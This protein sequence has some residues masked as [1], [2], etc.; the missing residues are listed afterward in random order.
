[1]L[2]GGNE[3]LR[4]EHRHMFNRAFA[5]IG[6]TVLV[7][8]TLIMSLT[9]T[10]KFINEFLPPDPFWLRLSGYVFFESGVIVWSHLLK[11][12]TE[13]VHRTII[14]FL[15]TIV[16]L[17]SVLTATGYEVGK[18]I[19]SLGF[20]L[21]PIVLWW[22]PICVLL[23]MGLQMVTVLL[24]YFSD[25]QFFARL[26]HLNTHAT[27]PQ[28]GAVRV[29]QQ[30]TINSVDYAPQQEGIFNKL[31]RGFAGALQ[32][33]GEQLNN[34]PLIAQKSSVSDGING[35][36]SD[37]DNGY[38]SDE[39]G[40]EEGSAETPTNF[41]P[42]RVSIPRDNARSKRANY[43]TYGHSVESLEMFV[44]RYPN[45]TDANLAEKVGCSVNT[46]RRWRRER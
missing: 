34:K 6:I 5:R 13:S 26:S 18:D 15:M 41:S 12:T 32:D 20:T 22:V 28:M 43:R 46:V 40:G 3:H 29:Q 31:L 1:M 7:M 16:S 30:G 21:P 25:P 27:T 38:D 14:A 19:H 24:Y 45:I 23:A 10:W 37:D 9:N 8:F 35:G 42:S 36:A 4:K 33:F 11:H 2:A 44:G 39:L 17:V